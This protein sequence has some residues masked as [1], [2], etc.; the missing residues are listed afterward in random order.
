MALVLADRVKETTATAGTGTV[1][2][3]GAATG[4]QSFSAVGNGN[5]TYY[6]IAGQGTSEWEVGIG[7]YTSSGTTLSRTTI[8][9]SSNAGSLVSFSSGTKD[10]F[11]T[12]PAGKSVN[13]DASSYLDLAT[14]PLINVS[15]IGV[16]TSTLP[17]ILIR[18]VGDNNSTS[19][20]A[21]RGYSS[22][23]N[24]SSVRVTKFRG[25]AGAPQAP[26]SGDSLGK[27]ELAGYGTTSSSGYPQAS[28]EGL[29]TEA[30]GATARGA[31]TVIKV[32][33]NTTTTQVTAVTIDQD[34]SA[35]FAGN[36][37]APILNASNGLHVN[38]ATVST[39]YTVASGNNAISV[40]PIT[41]A[42]GQTV[43]ISSG[44][45]WVIL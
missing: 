27:F 19:R 37:N 5:T 38:S 11:V 25:N 40:G 26:Q 23:A 20:I 15:R 1:T 34:K 32:T 45:R 21:V 14:N 17:D 4:Y 16:N 12:Y 13:L 42:S 2:L 6:V 7:T 43:T 39:S 28:F 10:V 36:V 41:I 44:S 29:A 24:S 22:D 30:W 31:K 35:T 9:A 3:A 18:A 33:P 8:L